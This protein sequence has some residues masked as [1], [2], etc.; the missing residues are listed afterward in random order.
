MIHRHTKQKRPCDEIVR[1]I[2]LHLPYTHVFTGLLVLNPHLG[3]VAFLAPPTTP[4]RPQLPRD[5]LCGPQISQSA[6]AG[7]S[8]G[9]GE[10]EHHHPKNNKP[11]QKRTPK[12]CLRHG[13]HP[14]QHLHRYCKFLT[15]SMIWV[16]A[17]NFNDCD[18]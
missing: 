2:L 9:R 3:N 16:V 17:M 15:F 4:N 7:N 12:T 6:L 10:L 11:A 18:D 8:C 14:H 1:R 5:L 13:L